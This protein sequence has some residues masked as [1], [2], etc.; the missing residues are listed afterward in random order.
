MLDEAK[1]AAQY[2]LDE[3]IKVLVLLAKSEKKINPIYKTIC[4]KMLELVRNFTFFLSS[5]LYIL[6]LSATKS[7]SRIPSML[8][9]L[10][11]VP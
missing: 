5:F 6:T 2:E 7:L 1:S 10:Y 4:E 8:F 9:F 3:S 11:V